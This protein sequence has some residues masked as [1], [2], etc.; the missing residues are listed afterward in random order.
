[1]KWSLMMLLYDRHPE[2][3]N[4]LINSLDISLTEMNAELPAPNPKFNPDQVTNRKDL[5]FTLELAKQEHRMFKS[6]LAD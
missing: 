2:M 1:M 4:R 6:R 3:L 5:K